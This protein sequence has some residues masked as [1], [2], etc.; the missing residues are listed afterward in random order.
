MRPLGATFRQSAGEASKVILIEYSF[1]FVIPKS[2][3]NHSVKK[4]I[5][6][7]K[8]RFHLPVLKNLQRDLAGHGLL[9]FT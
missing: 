4:S 3:Y 9:I 8:K 6:S 5:A 1:D 2:K 7:L